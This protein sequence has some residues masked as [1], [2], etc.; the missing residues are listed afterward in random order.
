[1]DVEEVGQEGVDWIHLALDRE[2]EHGIGPF[3]FMKGEEF[4]V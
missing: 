3:G 4:V 2:C 1:M